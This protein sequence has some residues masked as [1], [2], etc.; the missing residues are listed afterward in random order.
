MIQLQGYWYSGASSNRTQATLWL[1]ETGALSVYDDHKQL[2]H[3][4][5]FGDLSVSSRLGNTPRYLGFAGGQKFETPDNDSVDKILSNFQKGWLSSA[6]HRLESH[7]HFVLLTLVLVIAFGWGMVT[8]GVPAAA[9]VVAHWLPYEVLE[10]AGEQ[11]LYTLDKGLFEDSQ[12]SE[13][14]QQRVRSHFQTAIQQHPELQLKV[15]FRDGGPLGA[16]AFALPDGTIIFTDQMVR[17]ARHDDE[18]LAVFAHEIGHVQH[19][20]GMRSVVQDSLLAFLLLMMT[21][22]TSATA[23]I[24]LALPIVVTELAYSR[25]FEWQSDDYAL[26]YMR[27]HNIAS[28][29]FPRLMRR[30]EQQAHCYRKVRAQVSQGFDP[31]NGVTVTD[32]DGS[33]SVSMEQQLD[34]AVREALIEQCHPE[35][36][37]AMLEQRSVNTVEDDGFDFDN[38]LSTHPSTEERLRRFSEVP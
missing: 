16:N 9:K 19:R 5:H 26:K 29:H 33:N 24:F 27:E 30:L 31:G 3:K 17:L 10:F 34:A 35:A 6:I 21:G 36:L 13:S 12:L 25:G 23:E 11:T 28:E 7:F 15:E 1:D 37:D 4:A 18:L 22:D 38:Y 14:E 32:G 2:L 20:H 8:Q